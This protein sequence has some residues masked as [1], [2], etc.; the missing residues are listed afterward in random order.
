MTGSVWSQISDKHERLG[1]SYPG[2]S[3]PDAELVWDPILHSGGL[4]SYVDNKQIDALIEQGAS[5]LDETKRK[6]SYAELAGLL[7]DEAVHI[8]LFQPPLIYASAGNLSWT[9]HGD[10]IINMRTATFS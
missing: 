4:Q 1:L 9:P 8:P 6:A 3:G 2:W 7:K 5:T 10:S